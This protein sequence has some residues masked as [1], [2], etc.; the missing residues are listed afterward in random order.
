MNTPFPRALP[1]HR[2]GD[3]IDALVKALGDVVYALEPMGSRVTCDPAPT[4]TDE[5]WLMLVASDPAARMHELG[6]TQDGS[7]EFYTGN[8]KGG[9]RSWRRDDLN[10]VTTPDGEFYGRFMTATHLAKRFNLLDKGDRIAL[11]QAVLY[12]V[13]VRNLQP[14]DAQVRAERARF[15]IPTREQTMVLEV[16]PIEPFGWLVDEDGD[17]DS[18]IGRRE[19]VVRGLDKV[20]LHAFD[21][22]RMDRGP[23]I[24]IAIP[25]EGVKMGVLEDACLDIQRRDADARLGR[26]FGNWGS[27]VVR[28]EKRTV[29]LRMDD[30]SW[31]ALAA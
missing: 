21:D 8:D 13:D 22:V 25:A 27:W 23:L 29:H 9:F 3:R 17:P 18:M 15:A 24:E 30:V 7:P 12:N 16:S 28:H 11:F 31:R 6:F 2:G 14:S 10:V 19:H 4:D 1:K 20:V 5:D 26:S